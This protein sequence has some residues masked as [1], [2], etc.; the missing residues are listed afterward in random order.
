MKE[1]GLKKSGAD[2]EAERRRTLIIDG[3]GSEAE[4]MVVSLGQDADPTGGS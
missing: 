3:A 4:V 2:T 1:Q